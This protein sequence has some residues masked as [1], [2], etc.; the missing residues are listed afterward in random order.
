MTIEDRLKAII[1]DRY[2]SIFAFSKAVNL[3]NATIV[4]ILKRGIH[5]A[6][7]DNIIVICNALDLSVD[8]IVQDRI[9]P[10]TKNKV[11]P[12]PTD[13]EMLTDYIKRNPQEITLDG[14]ALSDSETDILLATVKSV[15]DIIKRT[16]Q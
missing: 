14:I 2:G 16:R 3:P 15:I 9:A 13:L 4:T 7:I 10:A 11:K 8:E 6:N 5:K 12:L 1:I